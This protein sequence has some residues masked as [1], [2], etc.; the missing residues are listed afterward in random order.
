MQP[1]AA[2]VTLGQDCGREATAGEALADAASSAEWPARD[3]VWRALRRSDD[4]IRPCLGTPDAPR[5]PMIVSADVEFC[6]VSGRVGK[7][8][9]TTDGG[10]DAAE[11]VAGLLHSAT[12]PPFR[13]ETCFVRFWW[14]F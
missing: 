1:D 2:E 7:V 3:D 8:T 12:L 14:E 4:Q 9:V 5:P 6:G 11:C 13:R 10:R